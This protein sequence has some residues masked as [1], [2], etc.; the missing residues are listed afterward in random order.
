[1]GEHRERVASVDS[2]ACLPARGGG[3]GAGSL[4]EAPG[5]GGVDGVDEGGHVVVDEAG[6]DA[7]RGQ[8]GVG[9]DGL[10]EVDVGGDALD[11]E[12]GEGAGGAAEG[13]GEVRGGGVTDDLGEE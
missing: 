3:G 8:I 7:A 2:D 10:Q 5:M 9:E 1:M 6:V 11:A 12:V 13:V 4:E